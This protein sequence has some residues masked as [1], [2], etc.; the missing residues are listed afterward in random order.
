MPL[1][2]FGVTRHARVVFYDYDEIAALTDCN[3]RKIPQARTE[4]EEMQAG[5]W[6]TV[7]PDDVFPEEF[8]LFFPAISKRVKCSK[9][10]TAISTRWN[11]GRV[12]KRK[13]ATGSYSMSSLTAAPNVS[14]EAKNLAWKCFLV[15]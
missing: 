9:R 13:F 11:S 8:R 5:T 14:I 10:C 12:C 2:N 15:S 4:E 1:K 3:F 6:Y 7:A